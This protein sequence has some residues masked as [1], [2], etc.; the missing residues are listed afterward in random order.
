MH[1]PEPQLDANLYTDGEAEG[2]AAFVVGKGE[3]NLILILDETL[4]F[5]EYAKRYIALDDG[6]SIGVP[7][8]LSSI[9]PT[10]LG[11][12]KSSPIPR[13]EKVITEDWEFSIL[14]V[15][16]GD[17]AWKMVKAANQFNDPPKEGMEYIAVKIHARNISTND[18][19]ANIDGSFFRTTGSANVLYDNPSVVDPDPQLDISLFPGGEYDGWIVVQAAK[20]ETGIKLIF[21]PLFDISGKNKRFVSL[22]Q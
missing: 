7:S 13:G 12:D 8:D 3:S 1:Y 2:W 17:E 11:R 22:E 21:E 6:A 16:R 15:V 18:E 4:D 20:E 9:M 5:S 10:D 14:D 19:A